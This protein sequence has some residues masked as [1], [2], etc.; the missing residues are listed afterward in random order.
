[1]SH[2]VT[3]LNQAV[4][5][6]QVWIRQLASRPPFQVEEQ[7]YS[8]TRAVLHALRDRLT[9]EEA[10]HLA[11]QLPTLIRGLY[12]EGWKP[13]Q[14][15]YKIKSLEEFYRAVDGAFGA[16]PRASTVDTAAATHAVL[17]LLEEQVDSGVMRHVK[18]QLP[19]ELLGLFSA[20]AA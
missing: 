12:Y 14:T 4:Q 16:Y 7:A 8:Y 11:A 2:N 5:Q 10:V 3:Q 17:A 1:M 15:P 20:E 13:L 18:G 9:M 19:R 6:A